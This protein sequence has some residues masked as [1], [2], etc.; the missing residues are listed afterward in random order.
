MMKFTSFLLSVLLTLGGFAACDR[1]SREP[2]PKVQATRADA[3]ADENQATTRPALELVEPKGDFR[4]PGAERVIAIGDLHGD[5][6]ATKKAFRLAGA[7]DEQEKWSG[8]KLVVVQTGDQLDRGPEEREIMDF[9]ERLQK[10]AEE[11]GGRLIVLNGNHETMNVMG[12]FRYVADGAMNSFDSFLPA[13]PLS[14]QV[15]GAAKSRA[16]AFLPGGGAAILLSRRRLIVMVGDTVFVH[17]GVTPQHLSYGIDK[18]NRESKEWMLGKTTLPPRL[19]VDENGPLWTRIYGEPDLPEAA[20]RTLEQTLKRLG[21][22]R[23][24]VGHT[25]QQGGMSGACGDQVFR[26]DVGLSAAYG[27]HPVQVLE[28]AHGKAKILTAP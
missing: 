8:G 1:E 26:I 25:V 10:E 12:D 22:Q 15:E 23:M 16:A 11:A 7:I 18:L 19:V 13:S 20:C 6:S 17:G 14:I 24:A 2:E 3:G 27:V 21:A 5:F 4:L 28:I 9:L